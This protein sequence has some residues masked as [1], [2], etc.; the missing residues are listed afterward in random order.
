MRFTQWNTIEAITNNE[1]VLYELL[2]NYFQNI[3]LNEKKRQEA[4]YWV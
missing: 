1:E 3:M 4:E 2:E